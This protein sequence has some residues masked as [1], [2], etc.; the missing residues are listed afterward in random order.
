[1][2][3]QNLSCLSTVGRS[4]LSTVQ[5]MRHFNEGLHRVDSSL[6]QAWHIVGVSKYGSHFLPWFWNCCKAKIGAR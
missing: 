6:A 3:Q 4:V 1:M 5:N 2:E